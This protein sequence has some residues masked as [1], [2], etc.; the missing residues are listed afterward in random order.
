[1]SILKKLSPKKVLRCSQ[2]KTQFRFPVKPGKTLTVTCPKCKAKYNVSFVNPIMQLVKGKLKWS[3]LSNIEK[4]KILVVVMTLI[5]SLSLIISSFKT[6]ITP[7]IP[8]ANSVS[9]DVL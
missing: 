8:G 6:P 7:Q 2:C 3:T 5:L 4:A 1:M 9:T